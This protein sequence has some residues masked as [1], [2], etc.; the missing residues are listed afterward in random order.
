[1]RPKKPPNENETMALKMVMG[2]FVEERLAP[3]LE[4]M[5]EDIARARAAGGPEGS[6]KLAD[7][8]AKRQRLLDD[9]RL[10]AWLARAAKEVRLI[11]HATHA[12]KFIHSAI[13]VGDHQS[14]DI[15]MA[16]KSYVENQGLVGSHLFDSEPEIDIAVKNAASLY[17]GKFLK[18]ECAGRSLLERILAVEASMAAALS[19]DPAQ[20]EQLMAA[21]GGITGRGK[22]PASHKLAKQVF[23]PLDSRGD[24]YHLLAP[25][26][27]TSL[28]HAAYTKM[29]EDRFSEEAKQA[30]DARKK[31]KPHETGYRDHPNLA[32]QVFGG[33]KPQNISQLNSERHG[34]NWLLPSLPPVW[35]SKPVLLPLGTT[36]L[37]RWSWFNRRRA[38]RERIEELAE[39]LGKTDYNN[40]NIRRRRK[41]LVQGIVDEVL[42]VAAL[43][44][45]QESGWSADQRFRLDQAEALWLDPGRAALD[46]EFAAMAGLG[47]WQEDVAKRFARWFNHKLREQGKRA[48]LPMGEVEAA[49]WQRVLEKEL[50]FLG[51][52]LA[53][54]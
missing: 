25:L 23:F 1:M 38:M 9:Y 17:V 49:E 35:E 43:I 48:K 44:Q 40:V 10:D 47:D 36:S 50:S 13:K 52:E 34:E 12:A 53:H 14:T 41:K 26:F 5:D 39:F 54:A 11:Q 6:D 20:A 24:H 27:P 15:S 31:N 37:F 18:L 33:S 45:G 8:E 16:G 29:R 42:H 46:P 28:V 19:D 3:K 2:Q 51:R 7:L 32:V 21:F 30:R 22:R 4:K